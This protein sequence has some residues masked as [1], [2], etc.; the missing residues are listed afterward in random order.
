MRAFVFAPDSGHEGALPDIY[1]QSLISCSPRG[2]GS[3]SSAGV[4]CT[5]VWQSQ[6]VRAVPWSRWARPISVLSYP[7]F[8]PKLFNGNLLNLM[9]RTSFSPIVFEILLCFLRF[10]HVSHPVIASDRIGL[11][12]LNAFLVHKDWGKRQ[13]IFHTFRVATQDVKGVF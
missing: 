9:Q 5:Y 8:N 10:F 6:L 12:C 2:Q 4:V 1:F 3:P 7:Q 11:M 13:S